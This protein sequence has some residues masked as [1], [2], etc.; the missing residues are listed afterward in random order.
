MAFCFVN[1]VTTALMQAGAV[2]AT[3]PVV[4]TVLGHVVARAGTAAEPVRKVIRGA[5]TGNLLAVP[6][7]FN[8][9]RL[10]FVQN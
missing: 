9:R 2:L 8:A 4:E 10:F 6:I 1:D 3:D 7:R 5:A